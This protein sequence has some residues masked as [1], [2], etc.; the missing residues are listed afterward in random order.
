MQ[1][2]CDSIYKII[3]H[4]GNP[5]KIMKSYYNNVKVHSRF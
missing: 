1:D 5:L 4:I 2:I 3:I